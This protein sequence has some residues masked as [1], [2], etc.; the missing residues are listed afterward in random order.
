MIAI[1]ALLTF[2]M[3]VLAVSFVIYYLIYSRRI[4]NRLKN[5]ESLAHNSMVPVDTVGKFFSIVACVLIIF[6]LFG[7]L[8]G[9][10]SDIEGE[11]VSLSSQ[12][13]DLEWRISELQDQLT[14]QNSLVSE[15]DYTVVK[16]D[17]MTRMA[18]L[19]M[20]C[21]PRS[22]SE[23]THI[24]MINKGKKIEFV[25]DGEGR[26]TAQESFSV[27]DSFD[28]ETIICQE[29]H[30]M[31][32]TCVEEELLS[33][34]LY[35]A[36]LPELGYSDRTNVISGSGKCRVKGNICFDNDS[37]SM[38]QLELYVVKNG[39]RL[40]DLNVEFPETVYDAEVN[41]Q[42]ED[43]VLIVLRGVDKYELEHR[44]VLAAFGEHVE[45]WYFDG[46]DSIFDAGGG[47]LVGVEIPY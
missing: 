30:G 25:N 7:E 2:I 3:I 47:L 39:E 26:F 36:A 37:V 29:D 46:G 31:T 23:N 1:F 20:T 34:Y 9:L 44:K 15:F 19:K 5:N 12:I 41:A 43:D 27:F 33:G 10:K 13:A 24:S 32:Q 38:D 4:N 22:Y 16:F 35:E 6:I 42:M 45:D 14:K 40:Y 8:N 17:P 18:D 21:I 28:Y 11:R